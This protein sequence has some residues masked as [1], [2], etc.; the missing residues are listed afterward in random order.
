[1]GID[2]HCVHLLSA[3]WPVPIALE[4]GRWISEPAW[5]A[6]AMP[7]LPPWQFRMLDCGSYYVLDWTDLFR[8]DLNRTGQ[9]SPGEMR[10]FHI[11]FRLRVQRG[12]RLAFSSTDGCIIR[13]NGEIVHEDRERRPLARHEIGV[14][15]GDVLDVAHWHTNGPWTWGAR[16]EPGTESLERM[17]LR[18]MAPYR[19]RVEQ[20]LTR[21]NGP[22]LKMFAA[23][24]A[25][26]RCALGIYSMVLNGYRPASIHL[27]G[28]HQWTQPVRTILTDLLPFVDIVPTT[29][30]EQALDAL[31]P[32]LAPLAHKAWGA[33]KICIG[34]FVPPYEYCFLDDDIV[35]L[36]RIDDALRL[37][38]AHTLV[39]PQDADYGRQYREIWSPEDSASPVLGNINTGFYLMRDTGDRERRSERLLR[40]PL[41]GRPIWMWEQ[42]FFASEFGP[43]H[44]VLL[45][46]QRYFYPLFDGLPGGLLGYDWRRNPCEFAWVHFGGPKPKPG[47]DHVGGLIHD[48]LGRH[49]AAA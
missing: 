47:D 40:T 27:F 44:G 9:P 48:I 35:V 33:M 7:T 23:G 32:A 15:Y 14:N 49:R 22:A 24:Q 16:W 21:P 43:P 2:R 31:S 19:C 3:S 45:P 28:E 10:G 25:P 20:A 42:G 13:L 12:G 11:V 5:D 39:C 17:L 18:V 6:P 36:D 41:N 38:E 46:T 1:M 8:S 26:V 37:H 4:N 29:R 34:L 30:V